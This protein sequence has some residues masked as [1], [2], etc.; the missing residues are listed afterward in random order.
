MVRFYLFIILILSSFSLGFSEI[1]SDEGFE[2]LYEAAAIKFSAK[3]FDGAFEAIDKA[4]QISPLSAKAHN[5]YGAILLKQRKFDEAALEFKRVLEIDPKLYYAIYNLGEIDF[6]QK[7]YGDALLQFNDFVTHEPQNDLGK[8]K[9]ILCHIAL[10]NDQAA[11]ALIEHVKPDVNSPF[12]YFAQAAKFYSKNQNK[13]ATDLVESAFD[14]YGP[15]EA[16]FYI[17]G[18]V[19]LGWINKGEGENPFAQSVAKKE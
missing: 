14:I 7:N 13:Q 3:D 1:K 17:D 19:Q 15:G 5:L 16:S 2:K 4:C 9:V 11:N 12:Y 10:T 8:Y 18:L 6:L